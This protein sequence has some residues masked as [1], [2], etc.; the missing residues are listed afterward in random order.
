MSA[1]DPRKNGAPAA[2]WRMRRRTDDRDSGRAGD[3]LAALRAELILVRE[4]NAR[5]K[6]AQHRAPDIAG[7]LARARS[8]PEAPVD[9]GSVA[10]EATRLLVEGIVIRES[11][12]EISQE[13]GRAMVAFEARLNALESAIPAWSNT[14]PSSNGHGPADA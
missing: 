13:I 2:R 4:E 8:L 6:A 12:L 10:D 11:L 3:S 5:L 7:L 1:E 9:H 14:A